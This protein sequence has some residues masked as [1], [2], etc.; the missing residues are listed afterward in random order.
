MCI[1]LGDNDCCVGCGH[2]YVNFYDYDW[3]PGDDCPVCNFKQQKKEKK[4]TLSG[5]ST[6]DLVLELIARDDIEI[7]TLTIR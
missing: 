1:I 6:K 7:I 4:T 2:H 5:V 3:I